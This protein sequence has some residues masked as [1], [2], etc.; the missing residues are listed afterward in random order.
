MIKINPF[1]SVITKNVTDKYHSCQ[2]WKNFIKL[3]TELP[4]SFVDLLQ[5]FSCNMIL[6][7]MCAS[8]I[9]GI[10]IAVRERVQNDILNK[11]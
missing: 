5:R 10:R 7:T 4:F 3:S 8:L 1:I 9:I 2:R 6:F 11:F